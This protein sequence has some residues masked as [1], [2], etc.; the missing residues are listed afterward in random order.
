MRECMDEA[1][2]YKFV[3]RAETGPGAREEVAG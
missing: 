3:V 1:R 2:S